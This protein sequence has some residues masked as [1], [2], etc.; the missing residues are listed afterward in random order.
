MINLNANQHGIVFNVL[1]IADVL[2]R[3]K[4][5]G[6]I[7]HVVARSCWSLKGQHIGLDNK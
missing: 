6:A 3:S 5:H 1:R 4:L 2:D 7:A